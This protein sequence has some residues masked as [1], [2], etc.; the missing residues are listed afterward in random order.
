MFYLTLLLLAYQTPTTGKIPFIQFNF[1]T[2][3]I[4]QDLQCQNVVCDTITVGNPPVA[5]ESKIISHIDYS[6]MYPYSMVADLDGSNGGV[7]K[8]WGHT[9][10]YMAR[11]DLKAG[12]VVGLSDQ[13]QGDDNIAKLMVEYLK[14]G[15]ETGSTI[16]PIGITQNNCSAGENVLVCILGYTT[17]ILE[18]SDS[19][20]ERGSQVLS[21]PSLQGKVR[22][23]TSGGG[24]EA[25]IGFVAQS[26][27][28][29]NNSPFLL[30]YDA[31]Y[32]PY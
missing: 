20:P 7:N 3:G 4:G 17:V 11:I 14:N 31:Y 23:N 12:R 6:N 24:N 28:I 15:D 5:G 18:N 16:S 8:C 19:T 2:N 29:T 9:A 10:T 26:N 25:R 30:Y 13:T 27:A 32:Q 1:D 22:I 21:D